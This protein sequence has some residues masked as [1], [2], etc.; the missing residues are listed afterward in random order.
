[1]TVCFNAEETIENTIASVLMQEGADV[2]L[3]VIDGASTDGTLE[4][5]KR[6]ADRI[7]VFVSEKDDGIFDAM[8]KGIGLATG[9]VVYF[10]NAD[11]SF[12]DPRVLHDVA[13]AFEADESRLLIYGN[14]VFRGAPPGVV[15][16]PAKPFRSWTVREFLNNSFCHQAIFARRSLFDEVGLFNLR[17]RYSADYEWVMKTFKLKPRGFHYVDRL[18]ANYFYQGR[19]HANR[20]VTQQEV[21]GFYFKHLMSVDMLWFYVRNIVLRGWKKRLLGEH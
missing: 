6:Y 5:I 11:D 16:G 17:L 14:V 2:E 21:R 20:T 10:L 19:S 15:Y 18:I 1:M 3:I 9:D 13:T 12:V 8:N 7:A 4:I